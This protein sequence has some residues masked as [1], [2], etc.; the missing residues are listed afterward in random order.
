L[1]GSDLEIDSNLN[2]GQ[3]PVVE[4]GL[5]CVCCQYCLTGRT[6]TQNCPECGLAVSESINP[7]IIHAGDIQTLR[8]IRR[9]LLL[10]IV[11]LAPWALVP[12][13][14]G[15][16]VFLARVIFRQQSLQTVQSIIGFCL[17]LIPIVSSALW[18]I[19]MYQAT[20]STRP[21]LQ[22]RFT[23]ARWWGRAGAWLEFAVLLIGYTVGFLDT[24]ILLSAS[25]WISVL[26]GGVFA[27]RMVSVGAISIWLIEVEQVVHWERIQSVTLGGVARLAAL[28]AGATSLGCFL[29]IAGTL[30]ARSGV[31]MGAGVCVLVGLFGLWL[32]SVLAWV[33]LTWA[34][35]ALSRM[36]VA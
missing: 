15:A 25:K 4:P 27:M 34:R 2:D 30:G 5:T 14:I 26:F 17:L 12:L 29:T 11:S 6:S 9:G 18:L 28:F 20:Q 23:R 1:S 22:Q 16:L 10:W 8:R 33:G 7:G 35:K 24:D 19:G 3:P 36:A 32:S 21:P 31:L 13:V